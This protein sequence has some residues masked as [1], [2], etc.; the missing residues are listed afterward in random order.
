MK[1]KEY[2]ELAQVGKYQNVT[3]IKARARKD[4][5]TPFYHAEYQ[6]TPIY[7]AEEWKDSRLMD[8]IVLNDKQPP[9]VWLSGRGW[10]NWFKSG[11]LL[12][13]L[14]ISEDDSKLL[15]GENQT[16]SLE[17]F[18]DEEIKKSLGI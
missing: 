14:I 8:Y 17:Q 4:A 9:I 11:H 12:S 2:L 10:D 18:I 1:V 16:Y 7:T 5:N 13:L 3:F 15:N 6:T